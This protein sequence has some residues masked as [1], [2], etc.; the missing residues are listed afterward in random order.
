VVFVPGTPS[1]LDAPHYEA[2]AFLVECSHGPLPGGNAMTWDW[3]VA[4]SFGESY[5][6]I[7]AGG[8]TPENVSTAILQALPAAVDVSSGVESSPGRKSFQKIKAFIETV[9]VSSYSKLKNTHRPAV[10]R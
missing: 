4:K 1:L 6:M 3:A 2:S 9:S 8:L 10:F 7:L 5:P